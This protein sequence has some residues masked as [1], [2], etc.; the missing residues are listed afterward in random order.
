MEERLREREG[1]GKN[2]NSKKKK[3]VTPTATAILDA[4]KKKR[5]SKHAPTEQSSKR[6]D[7]FQRGA[8]L[9]NHSGIGIQVPAAERRNAQDPRFSSLSGRLNQD[10]FD[11]HYKFVLKDMRKAE[12]ELLKRRI[13]ARKV[14]GKKGQ[15][16][17]QK[18]NVSLQDQDD[19]L[20]KLQQLQQ[21]MATYKQ[22]E[23]RRA[24]QK[25]QKQKMKDQLL[26][27]QRQKE[28]YPKKQQVKQWTAEQ[29]LLGKQKGEQEKILV[30]KRKKQKSKHASYMA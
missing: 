7:F 21:D 19:D 28:Y 29:R 30:K 6:K 25:S 14:P 1:K 15:R 9:L 17:R 22:E 23:E 27:G 20:L 4:G 26:S 16:L 3:K 2:S 10:H 11:Y 18:L 24:I 12:L 5:K 8:P 13:Q